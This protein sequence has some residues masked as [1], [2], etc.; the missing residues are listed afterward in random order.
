MTNQI[1]DYYPKKSTLLQVENLTT[2]FFIDNS[3][4]SVVKNVSFQ[5][6]SGKTLGIIGESGCGKTITSLS[7][8]RLIPKPLGRIDSGSV[9]LNNQNI[10]DLPINKFR[11]LRGKEIAMIFQDP[12]TS[13]NPVITIGNQLAEVF[14]LNKTFNR[15]LIRDKSIKILQ[16]V[17]ISDAENH[18]L[19]YP[20]QL[21]GGMKQRIMIAM[22]IASK[23][24]L[25]IADEPTTAL[26]VTIQAQILQL[27]KKLQESINMSMIMITHDLGVIAQV[28]DY[29]LVMYS[30]K[31]VEKGSVLELFQTPAHPY[32][33]GLM[34]SVLSMI[35]NKNNDSLYTIE[36]QVPI[37]GELITG[38]SFQNRCPLKSEICLQEEPE[39]QYI[40]EQHRSACHHYQ[41]VK[42]LY[43]QENN[44]T[45]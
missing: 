40:N 28:C 35:N 11:Q 14:R 15:D 5:A 29:V 31:I 20:H 23:P 26:D 25:L 34:K 42:Q 43:A 44:L 6:E 17:G 16:A 18:L 21:S 7:L 12:M 33:A 24:K 9:M 30:G 1:P 10:M 45:N 38:C 36:G 19:S 2:S 8:M 27:L 22:A 41:S 39:F 4:V 13:L 32:T 37:P 3:W